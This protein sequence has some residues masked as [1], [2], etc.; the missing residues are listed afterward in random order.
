MKINPDALDLCRQF[1]DGEMPEVEEYPNKLFNMC[2]QFE[3]SDYEKAIALSEKYKWC[4]LD[5]WMDRLDD[6]SKGIKTHN[7][8]RHFFKDLTRDLTYRKR[9]S[10]QFKII[11]E[12]ASEFDKENIDKILLLVDETIKFWRVKSQMGF[13]FSFSSVEEYLTH[14]PT[15][16]QD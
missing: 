1:L 11:D 2:I 6:F 8:A 5:Y 14:Q 13:L 7:S 12:I 16:E 3:E 4:Y 9:Y 10:N 15:E